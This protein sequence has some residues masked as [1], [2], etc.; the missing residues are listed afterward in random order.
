MD[1][2]AGNRVIASVLGRTERDIG[3]GS[4]QRLEVGR[5]QGGGIGSYDHGF[6]A[7]IRQGVVESA[8]HLGSQVAF[9]LQDAGHAPGVRLAVGVQF[10][11][12]GCGEGPEHFQHIG[13]ES[14]MKLRGTHGI[15]ARLQPRLDPSGYRR[16]RKQDHRWFRHIAL[17][18]VCAFLSLPVC[19]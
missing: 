19:N 12:R 8:K 10:D 5:G 7:A 17:A 6:G 13:D 3:T 18:H 16:F 9:G 2:A 15:H 1:P 11:I 4:Q 14:E